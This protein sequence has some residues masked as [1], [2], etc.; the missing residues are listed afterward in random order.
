MAG[1]LWPSA[2]DQETQY[3]HARKQKCRHN[4][5]FVLEYVPDRLDAGQYG[6]KTDKT[7]NGL[8]REV[9]PHQV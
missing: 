7:G 4:P 1:R 8:P 2:P 5:R 9:F 3:K 6:E